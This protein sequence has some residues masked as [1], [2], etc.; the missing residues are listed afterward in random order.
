MLYN[1]EWVPVYHAMQQSIDFIKLTKSDW[2]FTNNR[3]TSGFNNNS[4]T[5]T[6]T[7]AASGNEGGASQIRTAASFPITG[8]TKIKIVGKVFLYTVAEHNYQGV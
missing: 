4:T 2:I 5:L 3:A 8:K 1:G 6:F 7:A